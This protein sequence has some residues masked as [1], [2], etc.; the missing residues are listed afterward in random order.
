MQRYK[1][2]GKGAE[3]GKA[4]A[5]GHSGAQSSVFFRGGEMKQ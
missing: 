4:E 1:C 3:E 2:R 5:V